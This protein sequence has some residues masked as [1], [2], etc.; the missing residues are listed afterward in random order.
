[1]NLENVADARAVGRFAPD[2]IVIVELDLRETPE[3]VSHFDEHPLNVFV[4]QFARLF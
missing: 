3:S 1:L 4:R 2:D